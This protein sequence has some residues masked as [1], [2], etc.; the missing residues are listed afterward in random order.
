MY[1]IDLPI[2]VALCLTGLNTKIFLS[3]QAQEASVVFSPH[4]AHLSNFVLAWA[5]SQDPKVLSCEEPTISIQKTKRI[6]SYNKEGE[7]KTI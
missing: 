7:E 6:K 1:A 2:L 3:L 4:V 5:Q